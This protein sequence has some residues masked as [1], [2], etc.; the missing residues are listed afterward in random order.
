MCKTVDLALLRSATEDFLSEPETVRRLE[1]MCERLHVAEAVP[2]APPPLPSQ[3]PVAAAAAATV[4]AS[5]PAGEMMVVMA[6][7]VLPQPQPQPQPPQQQVVPNQYS[8]A[9]QLALKQARQ[10][11]AEAQAYREQSQSAASRAPHQNAAPAVLESLQVRF[12][13]HYR[14]GLI[15]LLS[16]LPSLS[17]QTGLSR[18]CLGN[19]CGLI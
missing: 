8:A 9:D 14:A 1:A 15:L 11:L 3:Q 16:F 18:A 6:H 4:P 12:E 7:P 5:A 19:P 2:S 17:R 13:K 10:Q